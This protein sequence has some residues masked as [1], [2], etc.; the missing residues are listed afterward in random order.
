MYLDHFGL[1]EPPFRIT[2]HTDFFFSGANRGATLEA[3]LYAI[4]HDEGIVKVTGEVGSG[5]TMLC[6]VLIERLPV[7]VETVYL[8]NPSLERE[9]ILQAVLDDLKFTAP[10]EQRANQLLRTLQEH[11]IALYGAGKRVVLLIDE[12][13]AMPPETLEQIRLLSN[14]ES[15]RHKLLQI[16]LF[17]QQELDD[18]LGTTLLR[19]LRERVT[20]SFRLEPLVHAD[21]GQYLMFR[22]RQAGYKGP[23]LFDR[24]ALRL[25]AKSSEGLTRR[26]NILA[27]KCL[28]AAFADGEHGITRKHARAAISD[29]GFAP[30]GPYRTGLLPSLRKQWLVML[31]AIAIMAG[32]IGMMLYAVALIKGDAVTVMKSGASGVLPA[33]PA[34]SAADAKPRMEFSESVNVNSATSTGATVVALH[35]AP[36][37]FSPR[38]APPVQVPVSTHYEQAQKG[39][40]SSQPDRVA[41]VNPQLAIPANGQ[42]GSNAASS[43]S[44]SVK[45]ENSRPLPK[46]EPL[47]S[48]NVISD[49]SRPVPMPKPKFS[50]VV[51]AIPPEPTRLSPMPKT[52]AR[53]PGAVL[54]APPEL[55]SEGRPPSRDD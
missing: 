38:V 12:A 41:N 46:P 33:A 20:H 25:I 9:E 54:P 29:S 19:P 45:P 13:H 11:L 35:S 42:P 51:R 55:P 8:A 6:R 15:N 7:D 27:D 28:L 2:P 10:A 50:A 4:T 34:R 44:P 18:H 53:P 26:L 37:T 52:L 17:G 1:L 3:L 40:A 49:D 31:T 48:G 14:L 47:F 32:G 43:P 30:L 39:I 36:A 24:N 16:A 21:V 22:M 5:K 23:D